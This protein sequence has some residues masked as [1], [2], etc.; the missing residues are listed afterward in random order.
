NGVPGLAY[1]RELDRSAPD[2]ERQVE[3]GKKQFAGVELPHRTLGIV[4]LG[5]IGSLVA[6]TAIKLGM[7]VIGFD[8]H[9]TVDAAW[10]L[11]STVKRAHSVEELLKQADFATLHVPLA[12]ATRHLID[13]P[14]LP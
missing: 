12:A 14:R 6:D 11:P 7:K 9:I 5:A 4:G 3:D 10:R 1:V 8:P 2:F 13:A